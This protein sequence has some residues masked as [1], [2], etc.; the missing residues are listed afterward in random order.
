VRVA[1]VVKRDLKLRLSAATPARYQ[2]WTT[3]TARRGPAKFDRF[4]VEP[5]S[6]VA[7][8]SGRSPRSLTRELLEASLQAPVPL[9]S[10]AIEVRLVLNEWLFD[11]NH[12]TT[13]RRWSLASRSRA[14]PGCLGENPILILEA[15]NDLALLPAE[16]PA[17]EISRNETDDESADRAPI[18]TQRT[19]VARH[20]AQSQ[21]RC[22]FWTLRGTAA[23][24]G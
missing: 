17:T 8:P 23:R 10:G 16:L 11:L 24:Q 7:D 13:R 3:N 19:V 14:L 15:V 21:K 9:G 5:E 12:A 18:P 2:G 6:D 4:T 22:R 1:V 20:P